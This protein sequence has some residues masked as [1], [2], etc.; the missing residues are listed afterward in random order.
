M[1]LQLTFLNTSNAPCMGPAETKRMRAHVTKMN[2]TK[3]RQGLVEA[4]RRKKCSEASQAYPS[5]RPDEPARLNHG[6]AEHRELP[7][8]DLKADWPLLAMVHY[9]SSSVHYCE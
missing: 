9:T 3:R 4:R 5:P 1:T 7:T 6:F 8:S 2:F